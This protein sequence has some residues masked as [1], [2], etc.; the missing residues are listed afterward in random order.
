MMKSDGRFVYEANGDILLV[1]N[2]MTGK[3]VTSITMPAFNNTQGGY[4]GTI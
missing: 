1:W 4:W 2:V 3:V